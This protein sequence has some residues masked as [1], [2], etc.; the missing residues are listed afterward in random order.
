MMGRCNRDQGQLFYS[1]DLD[2]AVPGDHL[3][4]EIAAVLDLSWVYDELAPH[5]PPMGRPSI[6]PVLMIRMLII[7]YVFAIRSER[8]LCREVQ[9]NLAYRWLRGVLREDTPTDRSAS[10]LA[11]SIRARR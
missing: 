10:S 1:F 7:G 5:Y 2:A 8:A 3:V 4:R 11:R 6:D 9:V